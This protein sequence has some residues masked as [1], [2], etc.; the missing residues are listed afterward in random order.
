MMVYYKNFI[1]LGLI[2]PIDFFEIF[3]TCVSLDYM[4]ID[5]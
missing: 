3:L 1:Y 5:L 2:I 4:I